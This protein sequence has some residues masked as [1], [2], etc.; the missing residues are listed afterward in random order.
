VA[1][2]HLMV[3]LPCSGKTTTARA[4]EAEY[5]GLRL[6]TDEW[7]IRLFGDD[8]GDADDPGH[9]RHNARH[10][11]LEMLLWDLAARALQL[12]VDVILDFGCWTRRERDAFRARAHGLGAE[13]RMYFTDT[14]REVLLERLAARNAARSP[15]T[16]H[17]A[18]QELIEWI[19]LF[20]P[21]SGE[22]L[23]PSR[24]PSPGNSEVRTR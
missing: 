9:E 11:Q 8:F 15:G 17:I 13:F 3:G 1:T 4:L 20:E 19:G 16:F 18:E 2:L 24:A 22:E 10:E 23:E 21:P 7:H 6:T 12:E 5:S 14:S